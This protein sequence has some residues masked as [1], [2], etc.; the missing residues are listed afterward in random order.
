[1]GRPPA[2]VLQE[3]FR[4]EDPHFATYMGPH[5]GPDR[6]PFD[7]LNLAERMSD[8]PNP[9]V[10]YSA[11]W[12]AAEA[13]Q[14][15]TPN[16][17]RKMGKSLITLEGRMEALE[18]AR[19]QWLSAGGDFLAQEREMADHRRRADYYGFGLRA[20]GALSSL[21]VMKLV[22][23][24]QA[25]EE[26]SFDETISGLQQ[27][28]KLHLENV[29]QAKSATDLPLGL[30][31]TR[32]GVNNEVA[33]QLVLADLRAKT[34]HLFVPASIRVD[35]HYI[36]D[37]RADLWGHDIEGTHRRIPIQVSDSEK[38][39]KF[40]RETF[41]L[42][43][44]DVML[45]QGNSSFATLQAMHQRE[46]RQRSSYRTLTDLGMLSVRLGERFNSHVSTVYR[47]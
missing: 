7:Y 5:S 23:T 17:A 2:Q 35:N 39:W 40:T 46:T 32:T 27:S 22:S 30:T 18:L 15:R 38:Y 44:A 3:V 1:M 36:V 28:R 41:T 43:L 31:K 20:L 45:P 9:L 24:L 16:S 6:I 26:V 21:P 47:S 10:R 42:N 13:A 4:F 14:F 25:G 33:A 8:H 37:K 29:M 11:G 34:H 12:A 19:S